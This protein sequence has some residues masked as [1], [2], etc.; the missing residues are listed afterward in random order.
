VKEVKRVFKVNGKPF[1]P[2]G[3]QSCNSSGYTEKTSEMAFKVIKSLHGNTLE[4]PV[5]WDKVEEVEGKYDFTTV[6]VLLAGGRR[7]D[8]KLILLWFATWKNGNM[9]YSPAWVKSNPQQYKR[10]I[11]P[12]GKDLWV[13]SSH[14]KATLEAD[15]KAF[16]ALCK[17]LK[18]KDSAD[19]TV[20]ALQVQNEPGILGSDRD[21]GFEAQAE[22]EAPV[23]ARLITEVKNRGKGDV[24]DLWQQAGAKESGNWPELFGY[25][26]GELMTAW[27]IAGY[28]NSI[29]GAGKAAYNL[30]MYINVW[31]MQQPAW[32]FPGE[33]Y[34]SGG[35][36]SKV[37]DIYKWFT[38]YV[39]II[40]PDNYQED[41]K[42]YAAVCADYARDDNPLFIPESGFIGN[43]HGWN[44]FRAIAD[45]N[46]IGDGYFGVEY[47]VDDKGEIKPEFQVG[48][49]SLRCVAA[50]IPLILEYQGTGKIHAIIQED[51]LYSQHLNFDGWLGLVEFGAGRGGF[52]G[53]DWKHKPITTMPQQTPSDRGRGLIIQA[54][55]NE[56]YL[57]GANYRLYLRPVPAVIKTQSPRMVIDP[58]PKQQGYFMSV[59]EGHFDNNGEFIVDTVRNGDEISRGLW[60]EPNIG[61]L[62]V[63]TCD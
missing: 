48:A 61:V 3:G 26:A 54:G 13:L 49:D 5:Y 27:S 59:D 19:Q 29:A 35:A 37:I 63:I 32:R 50:A 7:N 51:F 24:Y 33:T 46:L 10:V 31:L 41:S 58:T 57:V 44:V 6:D 18:E 28:I 55:K 39:D 14:C 4:I 45:Y 34:P 11:S 56:F 9:D 62:R 21:Y 23:P 12:A 20:I 40:A 16:A 22:F 30:P 53:R 42:T 36:V 15:K 47:M 8:V 38:P 43:A 52:V 60:V 25:A 1:F 2:I 17:H